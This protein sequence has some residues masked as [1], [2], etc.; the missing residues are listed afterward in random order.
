M[1][2]YILVRSPY[3]IQSECLLN[4]AIHIN[5]G[6]YFQYLRM[7]FEN[8]PDPAVMNRN[9]HYKCFQLVLVGGKPQTIMMTHKLMFKCSSF[10]LDGFVEE[11]QVEELPSLI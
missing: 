5:I 1:H 4:S 8:P 3:I 7:K 2:A 6:G 9:N 11:L 10:Q